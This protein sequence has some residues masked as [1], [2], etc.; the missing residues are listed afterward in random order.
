LYGMFDT[1]D[2]SKDIQEIKDK[3]ELGFPFNPLLKIIK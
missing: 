3:G 2:L 1:K